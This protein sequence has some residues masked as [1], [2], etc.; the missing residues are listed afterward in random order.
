M[1]TI[2]SIKGL[3]QTENKLIGVWKLYKI[4]QGGTLGFSETLIFNKST[5]ERIEKSG[6]KV[7]DKGDYEMK[8]NELILKTKKVTGLP[9]TIRFEDR[10]MKYELRK[11][12]L[13]LIEQFDPKN[14]G[15]KQMTY[16]TYYFKKRNHR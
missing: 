5:F 15:E 9:D 1:L 8:A 13:I 16:Q 14:T 12:E 3:A 4:E 11:N 7:V 10:I 6:K 2:F